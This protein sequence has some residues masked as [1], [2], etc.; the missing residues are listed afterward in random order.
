MNSLQ[1]SI[2]KAQQL[3]EDK[4]AAGVARVRPEI[5]HD[6]E[7]RLR[8]FADWCRG[9]G[10]RRCPAAVAS[11]AL[12]VRSLHQTGVEPAKIL[13]ALEAIQAAHDHH[14]LPSPCATAVVRSELG[15]ITNIQPPRSWRKNEQLVFMGLPVEIRAAIERREHQREVQM[16]RCQNDA[17]EL[18]KRQSDGA[19]KPVTKPNEEITD[20]KTL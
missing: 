6:A 16:R 18:K 2:A 15:R 10:I 14:G 4:I 11:V 8:Q 12:Y 17:A 5:D 20:A 13:L 3:N 9:Q 7:F 19:A 1:I